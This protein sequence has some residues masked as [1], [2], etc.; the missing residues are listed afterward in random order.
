MPEATFA[1]HQVRA[2]R[3]RLGINI[4][5]LARDSGVSKGYISELEAGKSGSRL[6]AITLYRIADA[7]GC[8]MEDILGEPH[9]EHREP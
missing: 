2:R 6:S 7:L 1:A 9:L 4:S 8:R 5:Q 3:T